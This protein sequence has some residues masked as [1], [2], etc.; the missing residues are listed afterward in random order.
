MLK[1]NALL[2]NRYRVLRLIGRG[3]MGAVYK[4][5][6]T[7]LQCTVALKEILLFEPHLRQAFEQE[8]KLLARLR[9][10]ALP[11]VSDHFREGDGQFLVMEYIPGDDLAALLTRNGGKFPAADVLDWVLRWGDQ[12][13]DALDYLHNQS[14]PVFHRDIKPQ[15]LKLN[16]RGDIVLLDFGLAKNGL[17]Q[18]RTVTAY[19]SSKAEGYTPAYAPLEQIRGAEPDPR[20]DLYSLAATLYHLLT[21]TH[22]PDAL[23]RA[24][25]LLN[26]RPDPLQTVN[27]FNPKTPSGITAILHSAMAFNLEGRPPSA[28]LMRRALRNASS[29][30]TTVAQPKHAV[31]TPL[32]SPVFATTGRTMAAAAPPPAR[33]EYAPEPIPPTPT[34]ASSDPPAA[35]PTGQ[36][37]KTLVANSPVLAIDFS[38]DG[39]TLAVGGEDRSIGLWCSADGRLAHTLDKHTDSVQTVVFSPDGHLLAAGSDDRTIR[40]W[41]LNGDEPIQAAHNLQ[42]NAACLCFS[43]DGSMLAAGGWG[44]KVA[45]WQIE[46]GCPTEKVTFATSFVHS[47]VFN[48]DNTLLAAG[49]YDGTVRIWDVQNRQLLRVLEVHN[50]FVLSVAFSPDGQSLASGGGNPTISIWQV[51]NGRLLETLQAHTNFVRSL[52]Y[53]PDGHFLASGGEDK[54]V[55][56]WDATTGNH[57]HCFPEHGNGVTSVIFNPNGQV[58]ASGSRDHKIRLWQA[59]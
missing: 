39:Q 57:V 10:S 43:P 30:Q 14:P 25:A 47:L 32:P 41:R 56:L 19:R 24:T 37:I 4:A 44:S 45:I 12:L 58:L 53:S 11:K 26:N 18:M 42:H 23:T 28:A 33:R 16:S 13:L 38:P 54:T 34:I 8:A 22:P 17:S 21:G 29:E 52:V 2:Q 3:G 48:Q 46:E 40:I 49:C 36:L 27:A 55:R 59:A 1:P 15:N 31:V 9:H 50:T 7:R 20:S 6:D 35:P 5:I 51:S